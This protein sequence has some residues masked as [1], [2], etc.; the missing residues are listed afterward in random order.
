MSSDRLKNIL[1]SE[2]NSAWDGISKFVKDFDK[3]LEDVEKQYEEEGKFK[4]EQSKYDPGNPNNYFNQNHSSNDDNEQR[5]Y[6]PPP[7]AMDTEDKY[8]SA[9]ELSRPATFD[10]IKKAYR[11]LM[12]KYHP[13]LYQGNTEQQEAAKEVSRQVNEAYFYFKKKFKKS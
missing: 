1:K 10:Q 7:S 5:T 2:V 11:S 6:S 13:D 4:H 12:K 3:Y 8:Y 9:L